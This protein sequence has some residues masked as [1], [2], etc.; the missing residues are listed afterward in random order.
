MINAS[1]PRLVLLGSTRVSTAAVATA[2]VDRVAALLQDVESG[3]RGERLARGHDPAET[4]HRG[5]QGLVRE[6]LD[7]LCLCVFHVQTEEEG[8]EQYG[9]EP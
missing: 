2:R 1:P 8:G 4:H 6:S 9:R 5:T 7:V 3:V